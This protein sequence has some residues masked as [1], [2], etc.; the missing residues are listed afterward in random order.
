MGKDG[1][2]LEVDDPA[3]WYQ[4]LVEARSRGAITAIEIVPAASTVLLAGVADVGQ[5]RA[6]LEHITPR[7][8]QTASSEI[9][10][11]IHWDGED[12]TAIGERWGESPEQRLKATEFR[13][14]FCGFAPGF[15]YLAGLPE[16]FQIPRRDTPRTKVPAGSLAT[17]GPYVGIYPRAT[18]GGWHLLGRTETI[19]FDVTKEE[20]ALLTPGINVRFIDA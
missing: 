15:A 16:R 5:A 6:A 19:L 10:I 7:E 2:L 18:P 8:H 13:V 9:E 11:P 14:A 12:L 20:P 3:A 17:A 4:A 1:L